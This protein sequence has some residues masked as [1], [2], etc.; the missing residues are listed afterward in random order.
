M[1]DAHGPAAAAE[2]GTSEGRAEGDGSAIA[3]DA[4]DLDA[5]MEALVDERVMER[6]ESLFGDWADSIARLGGERS[7][8]MIGRDFSGN[9]IA[10]G[11]ISAGGPGDGFAVGWELATERLDLLRRTHVLP[12]GYLDLAEKLEEHR[13]LILRARSGWGGTSTAM[14]LLVDDCERVLHIA[15][16]QGTLRDLQLQGIERGSGLVIER[17]TAEQISEIG[18]GEAQRLSARLTEL[19]IRAVVLVD[20]A[21]RIADHRAGGM[22]SDLHAHP[23]PQDIVERHLSVLLDSPER[24]RELVRADELTDVIASI[25]SERFDAHL[26]VALAR[27]LLKVDEGSAD[28]R[29]VLHR[30]AEWSEL[31]AV[32]WFDELV[33]DDAKLARVVTQA[34]FDGFPYDTTRRMAEQLLPA[35]SGGVTALEQGRRKRVR[36]SEQMQEL[37]TRIAKGQGPG[38]RRQ[39]VEIVSFVD[40]SY[41][42]RILDYMLDEYPDLVAEVF[43]WLRRLG[44]T[45]PVG[46]A[47]RAAAVIGYLGRV[48]APAACE[49]VINDWS[50]SRS[51]LKQD[52]AV[53]ALTMLA[54]H[55]DTAAAAA[56]LVQR[57]ARNGSRPQ[58]CTS[59]RAL[60]AGIGSMT[61]DG[62]DAALAE[63]ARGADRPL[64]FLIGRSMREL[65]TQAGTER[66][67]QI[68]TT[69]RA[70]ATEP[71]VRRRLAGVAG[72][73]WC[74]RIRVEVEFS[75]LQVRWPL[76]LVLSSANS[77]FERNQETGPWDY[78][79]ADLMQALIS[80]LLALTVAAPHMKQEIAATVRGWAADA[81]QHPYLHHELDALFTATED[82][83]PN[84]ARD[85]AYYRRLLPPPSPLRHH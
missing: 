80:E 2:P 40:E 44:D 24:A 12:S 39:E 27:D 9:S 41:A 46:V 28:F 38:T 30:F 14:R 82:R 68:L 76:I 58:R 36:R 64:S 81:A 61:S 13:L 79:A 45:E 77:A 22:A 18:S 15:G 8:V 48:H 66:R 25:G 17:L 43:D 62:I 19:G 23:R 10:A 51:S 1:S 60:G 6:F 21:N 49:S 69:L 71:M 85:L 56:R 35:L 73:L 55:A 26:L 74:S 75:G 7:I 32:Q 57:W 65:F 5:S 67:V 83:F 50:A 31:D 78:Q 37:R 63:L 16:V 59:A 84:Q 3:L 4:G 72:F 11:D 20:E 47:V 42:K 29:D 52:L 54:S 33:D 70:W 53:V 34:V